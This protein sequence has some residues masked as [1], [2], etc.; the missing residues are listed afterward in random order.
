MSDTVTPPPD[1]LIE[2]ASAA[3]PAPAAPVIGDPD[4][5]IT[6]T[7]VLALPPALPP[8]A[9]VML[10]LVGRGLAP[11]ADEPTRHAARDLWARFAQVMT[12]AAPGMAT[13][14]GMLTSAGALT[15]AG[16]LTTAGT[17]TSPAM[18]TAPVPTAPM[19]TAPMPTAPMPTTPIAMAARALRQ[20]PPDQLLD[21]LLQRLRGAL[22][23]GVTV[24]TPK[25]IQFQ[26]I[27]VP[28]PSGSR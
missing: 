14:P 27:P 22:P 13:A 26:L 24:P 5:S 20:M 3:A 11:D 6:S 18:S 1:P 15:A 23:P 21:M 4:H 10:E 2:S 25:G 9:Y 8:E 16:M 12:T 19:L 17:L 28:P 7:P